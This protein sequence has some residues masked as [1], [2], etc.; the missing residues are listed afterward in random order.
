MLN[1]SSCASALCGRRVWGWRGARASSSRRRCPGAANRLVRDRR[2]VD[3]LA[4]TAEGGGG[5]R[6]AQLMRSDH[7]D[8]G[9]RHLSDRPSPGVDVRHRTPTQPCETSSNP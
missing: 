2:G 5:D 1:L 9:N 4:P 7:D 3:P 8:G 6:G